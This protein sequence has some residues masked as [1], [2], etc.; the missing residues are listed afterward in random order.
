MA[1]EAQDFDVAEPEFVDAF[2]NAAHP[3]EQALDTEEIAFRV[4]LGHFDKKRAVAA[5]EID[6]Q[7]ILIA[8]DVV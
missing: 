3:A 7:R 8:E 4:V 5:T 2:T 6:L 1:L